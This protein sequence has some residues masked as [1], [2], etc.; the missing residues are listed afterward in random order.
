MLASYI[1]FTIR[2]TATSCHRSWFSDQ[3]TNLEENM[4]HTEVKNMLIKSIRYLSLEAAANKTFLEAVQL[5]NKSRHTIRFEDWSYGL[6]RRSFTT[7]TNAWRMRLVA[8]NERVVSQK[9][10]PALSYSPYLSQVWSKFENGEALSVQLIKFLKQLRKRSI[11]ELVP[12]C[13]RWY[14]RT[15]YPR[16]IDWI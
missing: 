16:A 9:N 5:V 10:R 12:F 4:P 8:W 1:A 3:K 13:P 15:V 6:K 14:L 11:K 2:T 7:T